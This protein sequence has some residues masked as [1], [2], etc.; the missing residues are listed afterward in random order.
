MSDVYLLVYIAVVQREV[1]HYSSAQQRISCLHWHGWTAALGHARC[2]VL[3]T[4]R[5]PECEPRR[6]KLSLLCMEWGALYRSLILK[7]CRRHSWAAT[8]EPAAA[9]TGSSG[10]HPRSQP[11]ALCSSKPGWAVA[12][13]GSR[14]RWCKVRKR[15]SARC[16]GQPGWAIAS[17]AAGTAVP[18]TFTSR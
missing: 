7:F 12:R 1:A 3:T 13:S 6:E 4:P 18:A 2:A 16:P 17:S 15:T 9:R 14:C 5:Q 11:T 8:T 10:E